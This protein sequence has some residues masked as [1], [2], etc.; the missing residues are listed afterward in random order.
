MRRRAAGQI[1]T[2]YSFKGGVGRSMAVANIG[3]LLGAQAS[4]RKPVLIVDWDLEAPGLHHYFESLQNSSGGLIDYFHGLNT[5]LQAEDSFREAL[6][7][8]NS[9]A[10][11]DSHLPLGKY[12]AATFAPGLHVMPAGALGSSYAGL[13]SS[14][15]WAAFYHDYPYAIEAFRRLLVR[16]YSYVLLDSRTGVTDIS[17]M[18][19]SLLP[20][21]LV[22]LFAPNAQNLG[23]LLD[24]IEA[25]VEYRR[26]SDNPRPLL[27][28]PL[29][30]RFD[31]S[32]V[33]SLQVWLNTFQSRFEET[34][35]RLYGIEKLKLAGYF[36]DVVLLHIPHYA[37]GEPNVVGREEPYYP[38]S[39]RRAY[40]EFTR[41][42]TRDEPPWAPAG[43]PRRHH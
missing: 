21:K 13:V 4:S 38:G 19:T 15:S 9:E 29:A 7:G 39:L 27:V 2:F 6:K 40:E 42:L 14:F 30:S 34:F 24:V 43:P 11:L 22:A 5:K 12:V 33:Y 31:P 41:W 35:Q 1:V 23:P 20:D 16:D 36:R 3:R 10:V 17:G 26:L 37:Y 32:D 18:C 25:A 28:Y 8:Q